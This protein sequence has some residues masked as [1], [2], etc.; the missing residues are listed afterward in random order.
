MIYQK[1]IIKYSTNDDLRIKIAKNGQRKY[2]K[3]FNS[4]NVAEFIINKTLNIKKNK[5]Y[6][7]S[8]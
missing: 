3:Y 2:L 8:K 1:K 6:F 4:K 7:W 5:Q